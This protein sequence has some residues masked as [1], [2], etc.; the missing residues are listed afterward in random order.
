MLT[1]KLPRTL[2]AFVLALA[3]LCPVLTGLTASAAAKLSETF[4]VHTPAEYLD[5]IERAYT[6]DSATQAIEKT[7]TICLAND[8]VFD[9]LDDIAALYY[10]RGPELN[11]LVDKPYSISG[12][13]LGYHRS[14]KLIVRF[15]AAE[16]STERHTLVFACE[17]LPTAPVTISVGTYAE[18]RRAMALVWASGRV[19][20]TPPLVTIALTSD[21]E[22]GEPSRALGYVR[23]KYTYTS[24]AIYGT[25][26]KRYFTDLENVNLQFTTA[27]GTRHSLIF[28]TDVQT[29]GFLTAYDASIAVSNIILDGG[30]KSSLVFF[31]DHCDLTINEGT[32]ITGFDTNGGAPIS[33]TNSGT[34]TMNGGEISNNVGSGGVVGCGAIHLSGGTFVMNGGKI[35]NNA[36]YTTFGGAVFLD[37]YRT[38]NSEGTYDLVA[39]SFIMNDGEISGNTAKGAGG[40]YVFGGSDFEMNGGRIC[41]NRAVQTEQTVYGN[42]EGGGGL[43]LRQG[44]SAV[45]N[46][47]IIN[48]NSTEVSGGGIIVFNGSTL[49]MTGGEVCGN[50]ADSHGGAVCVAD[51]FSTSIEGGSSKATFS[52]TKINN[53]TANCVYSDTTEEHNADGFASGGGA[54]YVHEDSTVELLDNTTVE[55]NKTLNGGDGGAIYICHTG[56]LVLA[57]NDIRGNTA[58]GN[59]GAIYVQGSGKYT[60][61]LLTGSA[62]DGHGAGS[63]M[64]LDFCVISGNTAENG[65]A[66]YIGGNNFV[67]GTEYCGAIA[68]I[69]GGLITQN[70]ALH[71][72]G[73]IYVESAPEGSYAGDLTMNSGAIYYNVAGENGNESSGA[74]DAGADLYA[75]GGNTHISLPTAE[76]I[77]HYLQDPGSPNVPAQDKGIWFSG[78]YNDYSD[79]DPDYGKA[80]DRTGTGVSTGRYLTSLACDRIA[81]TP[82]EKDTGYRALI[83]GKATELKVTQAVEGDHTADGQF[84]VEIRLVSTPDKN[85]GTLYP[86]SCTLTDP[87]LTIQD[88]TSDVVTI[89][90]RTYLSFDKDGKATV[91]L[92]DK[93]SL[94]VSALPAGTE[95]RVTQTDAKSSTAASVNGENCI[96]LT[97]TTTPKLVAD[98]ATNTDWNGAIADCT[99]SVVNLVNIYRATEDNPIIPSE[100]PGEPTEPTPPQT[101]D[102]NGSAP[103]TGDFFP[104]GL[105][106]ALMLL[107]GLGIAALL[108]C[109]CRKAKR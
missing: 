85:A 49:T 30:G 67:D 19:S 75:E 93:E 97:V 23:Y 55:N 16:G 92:K 17:E 105:Y 87:S 15:A 63:M 98:G 27:A 32:L 58:S 80:D 108:L 102:S 38:L 10:G 66:I 70:R 64:D 107:A 26:L 46:G 11:P 77:T 33:L 50:T 37:S 91:L 25:Y 4:T 78:W 18:L 12:S 20:A 51:D 53:N 104:F 29:S 68:H 13:A 73:G 106:F 109:R 21:I 43:Y 36:A 1:K 48:N 42:C 100:K 2:L 5:A 71:K 96:D 7:T 22:L 6:L 35:C 101:P 54:I 79:Q 56:K 82:A 59:G 28:P 83:L 57:N 103:A 40:V 81:Y 86:V 95:F 9:D 88:I 76:E 89:G 41:N 31:F 8:I 39:S 94:T 69:N 72:G 84:P 99:L 47:G 90:G 74:E 52:G 34:M 14:S 24:S 62:N 45:I 61:N 60:G 3:L 65:G 44:A